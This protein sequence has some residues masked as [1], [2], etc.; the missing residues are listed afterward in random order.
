MAGRLLKQNTGAQL[1]GPL[2]AMAMAQMRQVASGQGPRKRK[3]EMGAYDRLP[4]KLREMVDS[5]LA[6][7]SKEYGCPK[8]DLIWTLGF[9]GNQ[10]AVSVK[11][12]PRIEVPA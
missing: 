10:P 11:K 7:A 4:P 12:R 5:S 1:S 8:R 2:A 3:I 9:I 6:Q